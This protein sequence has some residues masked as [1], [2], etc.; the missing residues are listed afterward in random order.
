VVHLINRDS[1]ID[2]LK[3]IGIVF[4]FLGHAAIPEE[5]R[6]YI[7]SF[8][9]PLFFFIG[10]YL[11]SSK[12][13][14]FKTFLVKKIRT[15]YIPYLIFGVYSLYLLTPNFNS[16]ILIEAFPYLLLGGKYILNGW[17]YEGLAN[18]PLWYLPC[19]LL[20]NII[21][22]FVRKI[23][24][25][26][27]T[28][29]VSLVLS[30]IGYG[31]SLTDYR[32]FPFSLDTALVAIFFFMVGFESKS[33]SF[34]KERFYPF[35]IVATAMINFWLSLNF[36]RIM[37]ISNNYPEF[38]VLF[39]M[40]FLG[41]TTYFLAAMMIRQNKILEYIGKNSLIF[42]SFNYPLM[43]KLSTVG[44]LL[45]VNLFGS[46]LFSFIQIVT[47]VP[48]V[49]VLTKFF[50]FLLGKSQGSRTSNASIRKNAA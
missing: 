36:D 25:S 12:I 49:F 19:F 30:A 29:I 10:G 43:I 20:V 17:Y 37:M 14:P 2:V 8:H 27:S 11:Y 38:A 1:H 16:K 33:F 50:P 44:K 48:I 46:L 34:S 23:P 40:P 4:V 24:G 45:Q 42:F 41:I 21:F 26:K 35:I 47:I 5:Y 18:N 22:Y 3:G 7:Y 31:L 13:I 28:I 9:M 32:M 39:T 6:K 15:I